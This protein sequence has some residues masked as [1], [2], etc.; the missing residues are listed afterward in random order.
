MQLLLS[1]GKQEEN[2]EGRVHSLNILR[3]LYRDTRLG[4]IVA[5]YVADGVKVAINGF[6]GKTWGVSIWCN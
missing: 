4:D 2:I 6:K 5:P 3:A 1:L